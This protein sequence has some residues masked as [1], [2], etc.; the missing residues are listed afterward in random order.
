[1]VATS[2]VDKDKDFPKLFKYLYRLSKPLM[3]SPEEGAETI[4]YLASSPEVEGIIG[5][6]FVNKRVAQSSPES[7]DVQLAQ[8]LWQ[9]SQKLA[10]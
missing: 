7:H 5:Q 6:Y 2:L 4:L 3:K 10:V 9:V 8:R 1:M